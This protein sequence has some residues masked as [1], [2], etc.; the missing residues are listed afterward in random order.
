MRVLFISHQASLTG[1]PLSLL[2]LVA[3]FV[4]HCDWDIRILVVEPG[5]LLSA[6][7]R[8][9]RTTCFDEYVSSRGQEDSEL[10][11]GR[12]VKAFYY[13][14]RSGWPVGR[15]L[16]YFRHSLCVRKAAMRQSKHEAELRCELAQWQPDV[17][18]SNTAGNGL[19]VRKLGLSAPVIVHVRELD[20]AISELSDAARRCLTEDTSIFLAVSQAVAD[21][22]IGTYGVPREKI[23]LAP[24]ALVSDE[25]DQKAA[26]KAKVSAVR[27]AGSQRPDEP[28]GQSLAG[29]ARLLAR[30][31]ARSMFERT[32][33]V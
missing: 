30:G 21:N 3:Y 18:Y 10:S 8:V 17:I 9:A 31:L 33:T 24:V 15:A 19:T 11:V 14:L 7:S 4:G 13:R 20:E 16:E 5:P 32:R 12:L 26:E 29:T 6:F 22:L 1:A 23:K 2:T 28:S 27:N 25:I